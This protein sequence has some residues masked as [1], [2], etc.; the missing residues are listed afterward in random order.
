MKKLL[1]LS[2]LA[3]SFITSARTWNLDSCI[4][5]AI[6]NNINVKQQRL[7]QLQGE[8][9][10]TDAK[11]RFLPQVSGYASESFSF[12]RGL[13]A[14]NTYAN[15]N[16][17][18]FSVGAS[19]NLPIFQGLSAI[20]RLSYSRTNLKALLEQTEAAKDDVTLNVIS[21]YLQTLYA[22]EVLRVARINLEISQNEL[23]R[24]RELLEAGKIPELD[25]F[26]AEAA[27]SNGELSV[28]QAANDSV[29]AVLELTQLLNL[30]D[31]QNF[32]IE[33]LEDGKPF[34]EE[35]EA[36]FANAW[37]NNHSVRA[38]RLQEEAAKKNVLVAK[39]AYI[40]TLSF[41]AGIGTNYYKTSGFSNENFGAQMRHNFA[42]QL[43]FSLSVP[44]FDAFST[45]NNVKRARLQQENARLSLEN[46]RNQLYKS[47]MQAY[48]QAVGA[49][50]KQE[51]SEKAVA[52]A[53]AAFDAIQVKYN[54]GRANNTEF[55]KA[56]SDYTS[57][58]V[59]EVQAR[60]ERILRARI[61]QFYN[62]QN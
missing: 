36:V 15:R 45:R 18:S 2:L 31:A 37:A 57:A 48:T 24:R 3:I 43:G 14:D 55:E 27:V 54:N 9:D 13:T 4:S 21:Q 42:K 12:G 29:L 10:V 39:S 53:R 17:N 44:I 32:Y 49:A 50:K 40:P 7:S 5:Y 16:T 1:L 35:P 62:K 23:L 6:E 52:S 38:G 51:S 30:P 46:T 61:L 26:E 47:I 20:R 41:S 58:L 8:L 19:L 33:P 25:I 22:S 59:Q 60:Y 34:I 28:T 56:K 11:D